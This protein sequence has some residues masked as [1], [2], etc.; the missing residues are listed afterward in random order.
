MKAVAVFAFLVAISVVD[1]QTGGCDQSGAL[2]SASFN[3]LVGKINSYSF[4]EQKLGVLTTYLTT[5][6]L[7]FSSTQVTSLLSLYTFSAYQVKVL[8]ASSPYIL[9]LYCSD[10]VKILNTFSF[11]KDKLI[12]LP[13]LTNLTID[14]ATANTT[15][16]SAFSFSADKQVAQDII[17][18][19]VALSCVWGSMTKY[20]TL[21]FIVDCSGSMSTPFKSSLDGT[22]WTRLQYVTSQ[23][24]TILTQVLQGYQ[25]FNVEYFSS[26]YQLAFA[27]AVQVTNANTAAAAA[28]SQKFPANGGTYML[29]AITAATQDRSLDTIFLLSDGQP[30][31]AGQTAAILTAVQQ[32]TALGNRTMNTISFQAGG[33]FD[34]KASA[35]MQQI[36]ITGHGVFRSLQ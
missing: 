22:T 35:F 7:G 11:S 9:G 5:L 28:F 20:K 34:P 16:L 23:L 6:N 2:D 27:K 18:N 10:V 4:V 30:D 29:N 21:M 36:A 24:D 12:V 8:Q 14:L 1:A 3:A 13:Y 32:W 26:G 25:W 17:A 15:I 19:S 33:T 31:P